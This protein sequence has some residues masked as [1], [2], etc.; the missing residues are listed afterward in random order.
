MTPNQHKLVREFV[1][2]DNTYCCGILS[3]DG[4]QWS[5]T[6][7]GRIV[8]AFSHSSFWKETV[9]FGI[10]DDPQNGWDHVSGYRTTAYCASPFSSNRSTIWPC[11]AGMSRK[12]SC[13]IKKRWRWNVLVGGIS[14][15]FSINIGHL[16]PHIS[17]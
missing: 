13:R 1:L 12:K 4:H 2:L 10:E 9:I 5:T 17:R 15:K 8:E 6:A 3:A 14:V 11:P 7:F 16:L